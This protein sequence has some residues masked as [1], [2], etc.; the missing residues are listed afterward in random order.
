[1]N[2]DDLKNRLAEQDARLDQLIRFNAAH[3]RELQFSKTRSSLRLLVSGIVFELLLTIVAVVWTGN[4]IAEHFHQ[5]R[6]LLPAVLIDLCAIAYLGSC[7]RQLIAIANLDYSLPVV[8]VQKELGRL[9]VLRIRTTKWTMLLSFALWFP[10]LVVLLEGL[11]GVDLW[12]IVHAVGERDASMF[13]WIGM[14]V[15]LG[16][17]VALAIFW[18]SHRYAD[19]MD[20][21]PALQRL[22]NDLA[23]HSLTKALRSLDSISQFEAEA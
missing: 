19:R 11:I 17:V 22:M 12:K 8:M 15:L 9:R 1:M 7:I 13:L 4:F 18:L 23:G 16:L 10:L 2:L 3:V 14:N 5:L 21:S 6:F 20:R